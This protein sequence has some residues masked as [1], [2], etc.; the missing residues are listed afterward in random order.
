[1]G[2]SAI[3]RGAKD[4]GC[5]LWRTLLAS[6]PARMAAGFAFHIFHEEGNHAALAVEGTGVA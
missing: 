5:A 6:I 1:L 3:G 4:V 2:F